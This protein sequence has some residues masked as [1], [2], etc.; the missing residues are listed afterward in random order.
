[1]VVPILR[2]HSHQ[3]VN[4][5]DIALRDYPAFVG[6]VLMKGACYALKL[7]TGDAF[8]VQTDYA[9]YSAHQHNS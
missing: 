1:M 6:P 7:P 2:S 4:K 3:G 9:G 5:S 8:S